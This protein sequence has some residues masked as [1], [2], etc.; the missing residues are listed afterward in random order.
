MIAT[1]LGE[2]VT[3]IISEPPATVADKGNLVRTGLITNHGTRVTMMKAPKRNDATI[4]VVSIARNLTTTNGFSETEKN[5]WH[6]WRPLQQ[7]FWKKESVVCIVLCVNNQAITQHNAH[8]V[9]KA[10][11]QR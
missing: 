3:M 8:D 2:D 9:I 5:K 1:I 11:D 10:K 7:Q 6:V 4:D